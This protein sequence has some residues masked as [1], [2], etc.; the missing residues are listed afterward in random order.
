MAMGASTI[1][2]PVALVI[3]TASAN[4]ATLVRDTVVELVVLDDNPMTLA[5]LA[6]V[7][8]IDLGTLKKV[9]SAGVATLT[10]G[11]L[12]ALIIQALDITIDV[13]ISATQA[14]IGTP[15]DQDDEFL[16]HSSELERQFSLMFVAPGLGR[17]VCL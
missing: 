7:V 5:G 10:F 15:D 14:T 3:L 17:L 12:G 1:A 11:A 2:V 13:Q 8:L 16:L 4:P 9:I 6:L